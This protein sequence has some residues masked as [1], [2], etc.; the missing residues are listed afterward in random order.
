VEPER[1]PVSPGGAGIG[2]QR[3][4]APWR[5]AATGEVMGLESGELE[6]AGERDEHAGEER[7][8]L[9]HRRPLHRDGRE[10][11]TQR[12]DRHA[13]RDPYGEVSRAC[14]RAEPAQAL[15]TQSGDR[16]TVAPEH[17]HQRRQHHRDHHHGPHAEEGRPGGGPGL[18]GQRHPGH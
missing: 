5:L 11:A 15:G 17:R 4:V 12:E 18:P 6:P 10:P 2:R 3:V 1:D 9:R 7:H 14:Q 16:A 13:Q 8:G